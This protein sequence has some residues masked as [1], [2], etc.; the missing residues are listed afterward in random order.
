MGDGRARA[1]LRAAVAASWALGRFAGGVAEALRPPWPG[2]RA[3]SASRAAFWPQTGQSPSP[4]ACG[5]E[6]VVEEGGEV[7]RIAGESAGR[8]ALARRAA[9]RSSRTT[10]VAASCGAR[11]GSRAAA[12]RGCRSPSRC[13]CRT[14]R[15]RPRPRSGPSP[16]SPSRGRG[17]A[18]ARR[19]SGAAGRGSGRASPPRPCA[20]SRGPCALRPGSLRLGQLVEA[21]D[22]RERVEELRRALVEHRA[23]L[24]VGEEGPVGLEGVRPAE[25]FGLLRGL[26]WIWA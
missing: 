22:G 20:P 24:V 9:S 8:G 11:A 2:A 1:L 15:G 16:S 18:R 26:P 7:A 25:L 14:G 10:A 4:W 12:A 23:E 17:C 21:E 19:P 5:S 13:R 3:R 6:G